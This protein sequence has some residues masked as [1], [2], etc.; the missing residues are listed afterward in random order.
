MTV[1]LSVVVYLQMFICGVLYCAV[2]LPVLLLYAICV[3]FNGERVGALIRFLILW[4]G[5]MMV[6]IAILPYVRV[7]AEDVSGEAPERGVVFI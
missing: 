6:H 3:G 4:F 1:V 7:R 2:A 5:K